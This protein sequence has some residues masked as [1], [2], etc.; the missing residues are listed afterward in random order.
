M[1][2]LEKR[3]FQDGHIYYNVDTLSEEEKAFVYKNLKD[4]IKEQLSGC[5]NVDTYW[6]KESVY[7]Q[8]VKK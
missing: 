2:E 3:R 8:K 6:I 5:C 4:D 7:N 1:T